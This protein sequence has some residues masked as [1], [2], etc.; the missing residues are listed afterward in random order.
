MKIQI[1]DFVQLTFIVKNNIL[2]PMRKD[3]EEKKLCVSQLHF[4]SQKEI[5]LSEIIEEN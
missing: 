1:T 4:R 3:Q 2:F 5:K